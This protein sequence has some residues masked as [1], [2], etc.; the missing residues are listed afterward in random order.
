[1]KIDDKNTH[2]LFNKLLEAYE[3]GEEDQYEEL[4]QQL[5]D[6][7]LE[8]AFDTIDTLSW[9][10]SE[11]PGYYLGITMNRLRAIEKGSD[12]FALAK[13]IGLFMKKIKAVL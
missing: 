12:L 2:Q 7:G 1:M 11:R 13:P 4:L 3:E 8:F 10:E 6:A 5:N 9:M